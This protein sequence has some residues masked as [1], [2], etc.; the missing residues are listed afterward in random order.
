MSRCGGRDRERNRLDG[1]VRSADLFICKVGTREHVLI[2]HD[3][4]LDAGKLLLRLFEIISFCRLRLLRNDV[5][6]RKLRQR[7]G[8]R[9]AA[10]RA[11]GLR[12]ARA[13][14]RGSYGHVPIR[15][16]MPLRRNRESIHRNAF[17]NVQRSFGNLIVHGIV[18][19]TRA[20]RQTARRFFLCVERPRFGRRCHTAFFF[21]V[22]KKRLHCRA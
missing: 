3:P 14:F 7:D 18:Q 12:R 4:V 16:E 17:F 21:R 13:L 6:F 15:A 9:F 1:A 19:R 5:A 8:Y 10:R 22:L 11:N 2:I 20:V